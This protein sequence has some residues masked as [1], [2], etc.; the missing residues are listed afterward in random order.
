[1]RVSLHNFT[2]TEAYPLFLSILKAF[3][4]LI[5]L[6]AYAT[7]AMGSTLALPLQGQISR[8][9]IKAHWSRVNYGCCAYVPT[10]HIWRP[11]SAAAAQSETDNTQTQAHIRQTSANSR[12]LMRDPGRSSMVRSGRVTA[13]LEW[14]LR[15]REG[16]EV[17]DGAFTAGW[18]WEPLVVHLLLL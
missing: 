10:P 18:I 7:S 15:D 2:Q 4:F 12:D 11:N 6:S 9:K 5:C 1:M 13:E 8:I 14:Q 16:K 17:V 3:L